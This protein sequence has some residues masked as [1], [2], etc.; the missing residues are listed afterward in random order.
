MQVKYATI[1]LPK[2]DQAFFTL[3]VKNNESA[4]LMKMLDLNAI[5][6]RY[7][8]AETERLAVNNSK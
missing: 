1:V 4:L 7:N 8:G 6:K 5:G 3:E 2:N